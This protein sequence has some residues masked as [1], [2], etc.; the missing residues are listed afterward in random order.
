M[1]KVLLALALIQCLYTD[2]AYSLDASVRGFIAL[3]AL[4]FEK[5]E[6]Q[7]N[8]TSI[9]IG[10]LDLKI[11]AEQD[12]LTAQIKLDLDGK[13]DREN[14]IF[15]EA[16]V[17]YRG[18]KNIRISLGKG[19]VRFQ[20]LHWGAI[21]NSYQDGGTLI[22]ADN[23]Y[24]K[25]SR[26]AF[27]AISYG[28]RRMGFLDQFTLWG[29]STE[30]STDQDGK[31]RVKTSGSGASKVITGYETREVTAF[32]T[33]KQ[34]GLANKLELYPTNT[35]RFTFGQLYNKN[36]FHDKASYAFDVGFNYEGA[37]FEVWVDALYGFTSK[38][39]FESY[40]TKAKNEYFLQVGM[41]YFLTEKWSLVENVEGLFFK[42]LQHNYN[43]PAVMTVNGETYTATSAQ[44][45]KSDTTRKV[46]TYKLESAVKYRVS[47]SA[48]IT[49]G[50]MYEKKI[51]KEND[52]KKDFIYDIRNANRDAFQYTTS[53]S[54]W[55]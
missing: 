11:Y 34:I 30:L 55:F 50:V 15:E 21:E 38:L 16:Y 47:K 53:F 44:K 7:K 33:N 29:D 54:F 17:T 3:D 41:E 8:N 51:A 31:L 13:L 52:V 35:T 19:V 1:K 40:T 49:T 25:V 45:A 27:A 32:S 28:G 14:N 42:D 12:D 26:K 9:G 18:F 2:K 10:V 36:R 43:D 23:S 6:G 46:I 48:H 22:G 37:A 4:N 24:R 5:I 39:P 20:N